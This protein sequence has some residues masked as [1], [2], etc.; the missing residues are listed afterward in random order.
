MKK[1][2]KQQMSDYKL[3]AGIDLGIKQL[4]PE[5]PMSQTEFVA[6][7]LER[8]GKMYTNQMAKNWNAYK[9]YILGYSKECSSAGFRRAIWKLH[10][11]GFLDRLK[12]P[13]PKTRKEE[14]FGRTLYVLAPGYEEFL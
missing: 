7:L 11:D 13:E 8:H 3:V 4:K 10:N 9:I 2:T 1:H 14:L 6:W 5:K 12:K